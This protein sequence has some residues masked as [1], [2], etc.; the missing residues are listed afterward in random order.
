[1]FSDVWYKNELH[2]A[3]DWWEFI[4]IHQ[5][6]TMALN[7]RFVK[8]LICLPIS[9]YLS[10]SSFFLFSDIDECKSSPCQ[11]GAM[12]VD[13]TDSYQCTCAAGFSGQNCEEDID[14]CALYHPCLH[15]GTCSDLVN[16]YS[17]ACL[18]GF[19]GNFKRVGWAQNI[20]TFIFWGKVRDLVMWRFNG[21]WLL[22]FGFEVISVLFFF[23]QRHLWQWCLQPD[24]CFFV[25]P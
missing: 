11:N 22:S 12:C 21:I 2:F 1:M 24:N 19:T 23:F 10:F 4:K 14:E 15:N 17:C 25:V 5:Y 13:L 6:Y 18:P 16:G 8:W 9:V 20:Y 3:E 7:C